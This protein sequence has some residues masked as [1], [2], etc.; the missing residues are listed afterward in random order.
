MLLVTA[1]WCEPCSRLKEW[2]ELT[3]NGEDVEIFD[4]EYDHYDNLPSVRV[5]P[6]LLVDDI[7]F[8]GNEEI[9]PFLSSLNVVE[10]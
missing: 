4:I 6:T 10:L 9:R 1:S 7:Q 5:L 2:M 8:V 3:G